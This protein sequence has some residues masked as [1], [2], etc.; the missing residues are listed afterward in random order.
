[1]QDVESPDRLVIGDWI[2]GH[3]GWLV[4]PGGRGRVV[5]D[6]GVVYTLLLGALRE[7]HGKSRVLILGLALAIPVAG[8]GLGC[9]AKKAGQ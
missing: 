4:R 9:R 2:P 7:Q 5:G 8:R 1:V 6:P 3:L